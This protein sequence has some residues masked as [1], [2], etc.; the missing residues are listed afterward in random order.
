[1]ESGALHQLLGSSLMDTHAQEPLTDAAA[2][3]F[4]LCAVGDEVPEELQLGVTRGLAPQLAKAVV[5]D[6]RE[7]RLQALALSVQ[8]DPFAWLQHQDNPPRTLFCA[9]GV[10]ETAPA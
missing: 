7:A 9:L 10:G 5:R 3:V 2:R 8:G 4:C 1:E 6:P